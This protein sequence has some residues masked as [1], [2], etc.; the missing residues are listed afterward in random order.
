MD[1]LETL[2]NEMRKQLLPYH[3]EHDIER[4][5]RRWSVDEGEYLSSWIGEQLR[6]CM[7]KNRCS[8]RGRCA[9]YSY[10]DLAK[11]NYEICYEVLMRLESGEIR[12]KITDDGEQGEE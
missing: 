11:R 3:H 2:I 9:F 4:G 6:N 5:Q 10:S 1:R 12:T 8:R 7:K